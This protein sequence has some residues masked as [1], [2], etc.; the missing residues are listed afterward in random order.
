MISF[1]FAQTYRHQLSC[2]E[3]GIILYIIRRDKLQKY[4]HRCGTENIHAELFKTY[5]VVELSGK[6]PFYIFAQKH[7]F[8]SKGFKLLYSQHPQNQSIV[9]K[10]PGVFNCSRHYSHFRRHLDCNVRAECVG[11]EDET[12]LCPYYNETCGGNS[13]FVNVL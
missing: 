4:W 9:Q 1:L 13:L 5:F 3:E 6:Y 12:D 8:T 2:Y 7:R 10:A 11:G